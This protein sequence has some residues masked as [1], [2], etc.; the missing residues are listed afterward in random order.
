MQP[1]PDRPVQ[2]IVDVEL[3]V[4]PVTGARCAYLFNVVGDPEGRIAQQ[5]EILAEQLVSQYGTCSNSPA[6]PRA[7][8]PTPPQAAAQ[9]WQDQVTLPAPEPHI[10]PGHAV[11][12]RPAFLEDNGPRT[13]TGTFTALGY[14]VDITATPTSIDVDWGDGTVDRNLTK[15]P[16]PWPNG[17]VSHTYTH[18]KP[19]T[20][21][22]TKHWTATWRIGNASGTVT[23]PLNTTATLELDVR[24]IQAVRNS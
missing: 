22:I 24:Q 21:T 5:N 3:R 18:A 6:Q 4:D 7:P 1:A 11:T 9:V 2:Y 10:A 8:R 20:V 12:G 23:E 19:V 13:I 15:A 16:G 14:A 17:G